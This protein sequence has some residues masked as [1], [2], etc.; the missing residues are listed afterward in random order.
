MLVPFL[1]ALAAALVLT[2]VVRL[3]AAKAGRVAHPRADRWHSRPVALMGGIAIGVSVV[4]GFAISLM[5]SGV[6]TGFPRHLTGILASSAMMF[7]IGLVDDLKNLKPNTKL[8]LAAVAAAVLVSSGAVYQVGPYTFVNVVFTMFWFI[9]LTNAMNLLDN[10]DG[11]TAGTAAV[12]ALGFAALFRD[13]PAL[14]A[15]PLS[16]AGACIGFLVFNFSPASIFMGDAGSLFLGSMLAGFGAT[17]SSSGPGSATAAILLPLI[18]VLVPIVDTALVMSTRLLARRPVTL[19]GRDHVTHRLAFIGLK[20]WQVAL[21]VY[22]VAA[23][24]SVLAVDLSDGFKPGTAVTAILFLVAVIVVARYLAKLPVYPETT[25]SKVSRISML[26]D[27]L[28]YSLRILDAAVD[29]VIFAAAY[30]AAYLLR[31]GGA[32]P[33]AESTVLISTLA[34]VA[35]VRLASFYAAG[36]YRGVWHQVSVL[37]VHRLLRAVLIGTVVNF[38]IVVMVLR[39]SDL[40]GSVFVIDGMLVLL[41]TFGVRLS[42]RSLDVMRSQLKRPGSPT[43]IFGVGKGGELTLRELSANRDYGLTPVGFVDDDPRKKGKVVFGLPVLGGRDAI[44]S[45]VE[46]RRIERVVIGSQMLA[47]D[48]VRDLQHVCDAAGVELLQLRFHLTAVGASN[49]NGQRMVAG[50]K[51]RPTIT[52]ATTP[53][54]KRDSKIIAALD[55]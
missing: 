42:Y 40:G 43:L 48:A 23:A 16:V 18:L 28:L 44:P 39:H 15:L 49:G 51:P 53:K 26:V 7:A 34:V 4:A 31:W 6:A 24:A 52:W 25:G 36:I 3:W 21:A 9:A 1:A 14:A 11:I 17:Y 55:S 27:E 22:S 38:V 2:P 54:E 30:W 10:M 12:V 41:L 35:A 46:S 45:L 29:L 20:D 19:G 32:P 13:N 5:V 50:M 47:P 8:I 37:D 33:P